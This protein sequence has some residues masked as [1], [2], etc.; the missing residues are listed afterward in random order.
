MGTRLNFRFIN[1]FKFRFVTGSYSNAVTAHYDYV[2]EILVHSMFHGFQIRF[3][4][5]LSY[6]SF[7]KIV[8]STRGPGKTVPVR[9]VWGGWSNSNTMRS[10]TFFTKKRWELKGGS[11]RI[12]QS[13]VWTI[14]PPCRSVRTHFA[15]L[16]QIWVEIIQHQP[17][18]DRIAIFSGLVWISVWIHSPSCNSDSNSWPSSE[19]YMNKLTTLS[20]L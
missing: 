5:T 15:T 6:T 16:F 19:N 20:D 17:C 4:C 9:Q 10:E 8:G 7:S 18:E 2:Y 12:W 11:S 14:K 1:R 3:Q 13:M